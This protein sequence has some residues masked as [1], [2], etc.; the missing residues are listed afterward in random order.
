[1]KPSLPFFHKRRRRELEL[2]DE[3]AGHLA[4]AVRERVARGESAHEA[5]AAAKR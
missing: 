5:E 2:D 3:I 1:M 4:M